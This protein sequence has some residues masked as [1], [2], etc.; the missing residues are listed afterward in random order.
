[1]ASGSDSLI[2]WRFGASPAL[3][4]YLFLGALGSV[5]A[6]LD[7]STRR[8]PN[9]IVLPSY[10]IAMVLLGLASYSAGSWWPL[11]RAGIGMVVL[12][13]FFLALAVAFPGQLGLGDV[14]LAGLL[15]LYL[16]WLGLSVLVLGVLA[17]WCTAALAVAIRR[18]LGRRGSLP[19]APFLILGTLI[20]TLTA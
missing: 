8:L 17:A 14:K 20:A 3:A 2:A 12:G 11:A 13:C 10:F 18:A 15:G 6:V 19:L 1:L 4:A 16:A 5:L 7:V 9:R